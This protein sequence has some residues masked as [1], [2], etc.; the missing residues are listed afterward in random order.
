MDGHTNWITWVWHSLAGSAVVGSLA[1]FLP[2]LAAVMAVIWYAIQIH[3]S[4]SVRNWLHRRREKRIVAI[5]SKLA[6]LQ[7]QQKLYPLTPI[8][9]PEQPVTT[10]T[11]TTTVTTVPVPPVDDKSGPSG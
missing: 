11:N 2:P 6:S 10:V 3:E 1:G 7:L 9:P 4:K 8:D 5:Q